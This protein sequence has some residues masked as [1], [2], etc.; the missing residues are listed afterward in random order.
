MPRKRSITEVRGGEVRCSGP[1]GAP[2]PDVIVKVPAGDTV[3]C[4]RCG[5]RYRRATWWNVISGAIWPTTS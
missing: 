4:P 2:H 1:V 3:A 5:R